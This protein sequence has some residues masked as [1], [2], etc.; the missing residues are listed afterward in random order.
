[1]LVVLNSFERGWAA[2]VDGESAPVLRAD[3]AFQGVRLS[4]G[5]HEV[6]LRYSPPGLR[7]GIGL[8]AAGVLGLVLAMRRLPKGTVPW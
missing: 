3:A 4:P 7:E 1:M 2:T 8:A 5:K 6:L